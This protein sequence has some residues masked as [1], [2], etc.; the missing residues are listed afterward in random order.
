M[1][2][3]FVRCTR[4]CTRNLFTRRKEYINS[5]TNHIS[6][7]VGQTKSSKRNGQ[8]DHY[9]LEASQ[10]H[11]DGPM[12]EFIDFVHEKLNCSKG[13]AAQLFITHPE[14]LSKTFDVRKNLE[15]L[16]TE[17]VRT[18]VVLDNPKMLSRN[19]S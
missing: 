19:Q 4:L 10:S 11:N 5:A 17:G 6:S 8:F 16:L 14:L 13:Q 7:S 18:S 12:S 1:I 2:R 9:E 15:L 3:S